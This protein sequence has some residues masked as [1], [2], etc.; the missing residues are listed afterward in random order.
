MTKTEATTTRRAADLA[1]KLSAQIE[2]AN[3]LLEAL[4]KLTYSGQAMSE[5]V[6]YNLA[7]NHT[8][9]SAI[10][11]A[12]FS[13]LSDALTDADELEGLTAAAFFPTRE[14]NSGADALPEGGAA[15]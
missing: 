10:L 9:A 8:A 4:D 1:A 15:V 3:G 12:L 2:Q 5:T 13:L 11:E 6:A 7:C 14:K